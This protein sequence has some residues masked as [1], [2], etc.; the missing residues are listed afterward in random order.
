MMRNSIA[1]YKESLSRIASDV[2][3]AADELEIPA[4]RGEEDAWFADRRVSHRFAQSTSPAGSPIGNGAVSLV[5]SMAEIELHKAEIQRL[6][7]S[8]SEIKALA[9]NYAAMLK[10]KEEELSR[11]HEENNSLKKSLEVK[12][13]VARASKSEDLE[14]SAEQ[15]PN[16]QYKHTSQTISRSSVNNGL[17]GKQELLSNGNSQSG[18]IGGAQQK[19]DAK[20]ANLRGSEKELGYPING[21]GRAVLPTQSKYA[22]EVKELKVQLDSEREN[23][24]NLERK[25]QEQQK[26][27][28]SLQKEL[29]D[30][31]MEKERMSLDIKDMQNDMDTNV[32]E[33]KRL[34]LEV[35]RRKLTEASNESLDRLRNE[36]LTLQNENM[37]LKR[38]KAEVE[39]TLKHR[40]DNRQEKSE[41]TNS[42]PS[43]R[44]DNLDEVNE[45]MT[46]KIQ[47]LEKSLVVT[48]KERDK[49]LHELNRLKKHLLDKELE[50][51]D[52]M[53]EDSKL[54][55]ELQAHVAS[56]RAHILKL[57]RA[58]KQENL[59]NE[60][61]HKMKSDELHQANEIING[62]KQKVT[63]YMSN[64]ESKNAELLNL[65]TALGQYYAEAEA[66]ERLERDMV[67]AREETA[68]LSGSLKAANELL[69][70]S[71][72]EK[73]EV[74]SKLA[75][76]ER[77]LS[78]GKLTVQ[79]LQEDNSK[80]RRTLEQSM[81]RINRMSLDSDYSVD[82][83]IVIKL[84]V[85][86]FERNHSKEVRHNQV[87]DLMVRMLGFSEEDKQRIGLAQQAARKGVVRG[88]LGFPGRLVG[89]ILGGA[90][91]EGSHS[92][93]ENQSFADLWVDFLLKET[94]ERE[95]RELAEASKKSSSGTQQNTGATQ[96]PPAPD[97]RTTAIPSSTSATFS[98]LHPYPHRFSTPAPSRQP[99]LFEQSDAEFATVPL[100]SS[101]SP[102]EGGSPFSRRPP[103]Y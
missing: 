75:Q 68:K 65:Q 48:S 81:T 2:Q 90:S 32:S 14:G 77:M 59:K 38:E 95:K 10:E 55:E 18:Q 72:N 45:E 35:N 46:K 30:L 63:N 8:E 34:E 91:P 24:A 87:L 74:I 60:E 9:V 11:I 100:T 36:V 97:Y 85:T 54:I 16:R 15:S 88:V 28:E 67:V 33:I 13:A 94:E 27:N 70:R 43:N 101:A 1:T 64:L 52:K 76:A 5:P 62:L 19:I 61:V 86:Y 3:D 22:S 102:P 56:Q 58:L 7:T 71:K 57:E 12:T 96:V 79:K 25:Y 49:A 37:K 93:S 44:L 4:P 26:K 39:V 84:L 50:E 98:T 31:K 40:M 80:L 89:G 47:Q 17:R 42:G 21:N 69:E 92:L 41:T 83:R 82:R 51:S 73:E 78:E 66:K 23:L 6:K 29:H 103:R 99:Q 20:V 53:D